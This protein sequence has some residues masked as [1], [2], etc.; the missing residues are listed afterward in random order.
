MTQNSDHLRDEIIYRQTIARLQAGQMA[1]NDLT[2]GECNRM[3]RIAG[4]KEKRDRQRIEVL[5][6]RGKIAAATKAQR[7]YL[8]SFSARYVAANYATHVEGGDP[9]VRFPI[10]Y[11]R[12]NL[13]GFGAT[14][15]DMWL[16]KK[17]KARGGCRVTGRFRDTD[18]AQQK[19]IAN[20]LLPFFGDHPEQ[21]AQRGKDLAVENL[22]GLA[23]EAGL[24]AAFLHGDVLQ[25]Y[26]NVSHDWLRENVPMPASLANWMLT[27]GYSIRSRS[28]RRQALRITQEE[29]DRMARCGLPQGSVLSP[30]VAEL[31]IAR[32]IA[33]VG[34]LRRFPLVNYSDNFGLICSADEATHLEQTLREGFGSHPAG[35][36]DLRFTR[37][38]LSAECRFAGYS[39]SLQDNGKCD[40]W[41]RETDWRNRFAYWAD[42]LQNEPRD[43]A[44]KNINGM[45]G[46]LRAFPHWN[47][48]DQ[49]RHEWEAH[50][51]SVLQD[52]DWEDLIP[53]A[54]STSLSEETP[55]PPSLRALAEESTPT[56]GKANAIMDCRSRVRT[57]TCS[58]ENALPWN[59]D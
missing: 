55:D 22:K 50:V 46:Y 21:F 45:L 18:K 58:S 54:F 33:E 44:M 37:T 14:P 11:A 25:F 19:L 6:S 38:Q 10:V 16:V 39:F 34:P 2:R 47:G 56:D 7:A 57:Q 29:I 5:F 27:S 20:S 15:T 1:P 30:Y 41:V 42:K 13:I 23:E 8:H 43:R 32:I 24:D 4:R 3:M 26:D 17:Q 48:K 9:R 49:V 31:V 40:V 12:A 59:I 52:R 28:S 51:V 53:P 35:P 36:F